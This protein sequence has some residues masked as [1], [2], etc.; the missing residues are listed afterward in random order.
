MLHVYK[1][2][3]ALSAHLPSY[4]EQLLLIPNSWTSACLISKYLVNDSCDWLRIWQG[5]LT[6]PQDVSH[7]VQFAHMPCSMIINKLTTFWTRA[8]V[9]KSQLDCKMHT[10][11]LDGRLLEEKNYFLMV[12][13]IKRHTADK[14][15]WAAL[16]KL[17]LCLVMSYFTWQRCLKRV[18]TCKFTTGVQ[19]R[20]R[21]PY[22]NLSVA[23]LAGWS[24]KVPREPN[25]HRST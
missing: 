13:S 14:A 8:Q 2:D 5:V 9:F 1:I 15:Y 16:S 12:C 4:L 24:V 3:T 21:K 19:Q 6:G 7:M 20:K 18:S 10:E 22:W 25:W 23:S 17:L 11:R